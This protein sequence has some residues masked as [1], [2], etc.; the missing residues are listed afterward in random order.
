M[1]KYAGWSLAHEIGHYALGHGKIRPSSLTSS[2]QRRY[3]LAADAFAARLGYGEEMLEDFISSQNINWPSGGSHPSW[4][5]R[6]AQARAIMS[7][8]KPLTQT[9]TD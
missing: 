8:L 9:A 6:I 2:D 1:S 4:D 3:E 5:E 7:E